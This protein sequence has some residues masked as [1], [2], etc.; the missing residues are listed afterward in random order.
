MSGRA[1][2]DGFHLKFAIGRALWNDLFAASLPFRIGRGRF[3]LLRAVH[4]GY[5]QLQ[6]RDRVRGLLEDQQVQVPEVLVRGVAVARGAW[7]G[8]RDDVV[9][10]VDRLVRVEG[11]WTVEIDREG[12][13]FR[14]AD[15]R[16]GV[17]AH[18]RGVLT[19]KVVLPTQNVEIP[20]TLERRVGAEA[21]LGD[22]R[23]DRERRALVGTLQ[24]VT[25]H[26]GEHA[27][28]QLL[29]RGAE[30]LLAQQVPTV[31]PVTILPKSHVEDLVGPMGG[32][33]NLKLA[34]EDVALDIDAEEL[35]LKVKFGFT[36]LQLESGRA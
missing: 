8:R 13:A 17:E 7:D 36:Q 20:F 21:A 6:V 15:Q 19:G 24:D 32:P 4:A 14:Y 27:L 34:V 31:N 30:H 26:L 2:S 18:L 11:D 29:A 10:F 16:F 12:S 22:I 25:V 23:Y 3:D 28:L 1:L 5:R 35:T 9:A 33:L